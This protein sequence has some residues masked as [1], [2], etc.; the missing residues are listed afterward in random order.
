[1]SSDGVREARLWSWLKTA[2]LAFTERLHMNRVENRVGAGCS[3][4][5]ACFGGVQLWIELKTAPRPVKPG[6]RVKPRFETSQWPWHRR[7]HQAGTPTFVLLQVGQ[8]AGDGVGRY[9]LPG[10]LIPQLESPGLTEYELRE[11]ALCPPSARATEVLLAARRYVM[12]CV[13]PG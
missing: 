12:D 6:T 3:D 11:A 10:T 5:E 8:G 1:M 2:S 4:V 9:L 7:R 13:S